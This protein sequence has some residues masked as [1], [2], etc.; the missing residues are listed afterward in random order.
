MLIFK[1]Q[2]PELYSVAL[3]FCDLPW[4]GCLLF[5]FYLVF[6]LHLDCVLNGGDNSFV[7][8]N[9]NVL[10]LI[11]LHDIYDLPR[12]ALFF[13]KLQG[14]HLLIFEVNGDIFIISGVHNLQ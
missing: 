11:F 6:K 14:L 3:L 9:Y 2:R 7:P 8:F 5:S 1:E 10:V 13:M 4:Y 12:G